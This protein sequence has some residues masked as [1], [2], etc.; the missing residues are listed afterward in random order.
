[1]DT[2][3][4]GQASFQATLTNIGGNDRDDMFLCSRK[5]GAKKGE[6]QFCEAVKVDVSKIKETNFQSSITNTIALV[7]VLF[8][9]V[10]VATELI[11]MAKKEKKSEVPFP[12]GHSILFNQTFEFEKGFFENFVNVHQKECLKTFQSLCV[13]GYREFYK[14]LLCILV[15]MHHQ[16]YSKKTPVPKRIMDMFGLSTGPLVAHMMNRGKFEK[17]KFSQAYRMDFN[18]SPKIVGNSVTRPVQVSLGAL[19]SGAAFTEKHGHGWNPTNVAEY[20]QVSTSDED[21]REIRKEQKMISSKQFEAYHVMLWTMR[22][23][24]VTKGKNSEKKQYHIQCQTKNYQY[25]NS[26]I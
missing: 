6:H 15:E 25:G 16:I 17:T 18:N 2:Y 20:F 23:I 13:F 9:D 7:E 8:E 5:N 22:N 14:N 4:G 1:M 3:V 10:G 26:G 24:K 21:N 12:S 11:E 19:P